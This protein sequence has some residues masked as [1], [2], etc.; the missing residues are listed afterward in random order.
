MNG[1]LDKQLVITYL[2]SIEAQ[3]QSMVIEISTRI[4][5]LRTYIESLESEE[6]K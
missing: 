4:E 2:A 1:K 6:N 5:N 3:L